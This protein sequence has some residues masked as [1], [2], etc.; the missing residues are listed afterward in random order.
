MQVSEYGYSCTGHFSAWTRC[1]AD[2][3]EAGR[4]RFEFADALDIPAL[5][6][7]WKYKPRTRLFPV[8]KS[9]PAPAAPAVASPTPA[10]AAG[11]GSAAAAAPS[12]PPAPNPEMF[13][14]MVRGFVALLIVRGGG[15]DARARGTFAASPAFRRRAVF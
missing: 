2:A 13:A 11:G 3:S 5:K 10:A 8:R 14:G 15:E 4:H 1:S 6:P 12:G 7:Y 9:A